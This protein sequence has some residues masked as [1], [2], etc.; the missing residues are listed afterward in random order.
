MFLDRYCSLNSGEENEIGVYTYVEFL[1]ERTILLVDINKTWLIVA[2]GIC[3]GSDD[4]I[5]LV[6]I[7]KDARRSRSHLALLKAVH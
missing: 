4:N 7:R 3:V 6:E 1:H 2:L 5:V